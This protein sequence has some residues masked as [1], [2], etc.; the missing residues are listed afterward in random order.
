MKKIREQSILTKLLIVLFMCQFIAIAYINLTQ[1]QYHLGFDY[2]INFLKTIQIVKQH[3]LIIDHWQSTTGYSLLDVNILAVPFYAITKNIF[4]SFG[5]ANILMVSFT[6]WVFW[7]IFRILN[8]SINSTL[9]GLNFFICSFATIEFNNS[10]DLGYASDMLIGANYYG[11]TMLLV[12]LTLLYVWTDMS[13]KK[14]WIYGGLLTVFITLLSATNG[15]L[16]WGLFLVPVCLYDVINS[17]V[18]NDLGKLKSRMFVFG[19]ANVILSPVANILS[20]TGGEGTSGLELVTLDIFWKHF[21]SIFAGILKFLGCLPTEGV[22]SPTSISGIAY[23]C[24]CGVLVLLL[25][26]VGYAVICLFKKMSTP[27]MRLLLWIIAENILFFSFV[28]TDYGEEI[29]ECRYLLIIIYAMLIL[30]VMFLN[31][32]LNMDKVKHIVIT[33]LALGMIFVLDV[34]GDRNIYKIRIDYDQLKQISEYVHK[35]DSPVVYVWND[36]MAA[37]RLRVIDADRVYRN[38]VGVNAASAWGEYLFYQDNAE[39]NGDN[40]MIIVDDNYENIPQWLLDTYTLEYTINKYKIYHSEVSKFDF[41]SAIGEHTIDFPYSIAYA[42]YSSEYDDEGSLVTDGTEGYCL[43][44]PEQ[45][46]ET[47]GTYSAKLS[48]E[49][50]KMGKGDNIFEIVANDG[51]SV[52]SQCVLDAEENEAILKDIVYNADETIS[53]RVYNSDGTIMKINYIEVNKND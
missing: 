11:V 50:E 51:T 17:F 28:N 48:Y 33:V 53:Y 40:Y 39:Y 36:E 16:I 9:V 42:K 49:I 18:Y 10:N 21:G 44:G 26:G 27:Q 1:L 25:V 4:V 7:K 43:A 37:R 2:S 24:S 15:L 38:A 14:Q 30:S 5:I 31:D 23:A 45:T 12:L 29:F 32:M 22:V 47:T 52:L 46:V 35:S 19:M 20:S 34:V 3:K 41:S 8:I 6:A 13:R